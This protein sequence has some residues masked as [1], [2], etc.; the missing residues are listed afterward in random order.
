MRPFDDDDLV[1]A[2]R[3]PETD[4]HR[5]Q[6]LQLL[7]AAVPRR[8]AGRQDDRG[9]QWTE[10]VACRISIRRVGCSVVE[11]PNFPISCTTAW[12]FTTWPRTA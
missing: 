9:D 8:G 11:S 5:G 4:E 7:R 10:T 3:L 12:P 1:D 6:E 2:G